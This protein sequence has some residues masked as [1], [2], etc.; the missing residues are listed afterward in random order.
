MLPS[1]AST[2]SP[3]SMDIAAMQSLRL[4]DSAASAAAV[5]ELLP[6]NDLALSPPTEHDA[7]QPLQQR[8]Q[9]LMSQ[10]SSIVESALAAPQSADRSEGL[11]V[12]VQHPTAIHTRRPNRVAQE[13]PVSQAA[14]AAALPASMQ[15]VV[16]TS[17]QHLRQYNLLQAEAQNLNAADQQQQQQQQQ[18]QQQSTSGGCA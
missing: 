13:M 8:N 9:Q 14:S 15:Q 10:V 18:H 17:Q 16:C 12:T 7:S 4:D 1:N 6:I 11:A 3:G 2:G 5:Y